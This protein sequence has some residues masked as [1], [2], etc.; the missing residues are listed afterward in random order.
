MTRRPVRALRSFT[1]A[2]SSCNPEPRG[3][4]EEAV[5]S[6]AS[7]WLNAL[8]ITLGCDVQADRKSRSAQTGS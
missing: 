3:K 7:F 5:K 8:R 2:P 1:R 4:K 6:T